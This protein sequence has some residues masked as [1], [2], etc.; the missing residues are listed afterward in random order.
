[1]AVGTV[2][3]TTTDI[4]SDSRGGYLGITKYSLAWIASAGGAVSGNPVTT[5]RGTLVAAKVVPGTGTPP[6]GGYGV[7]LVDTDGVD[8]LGG[9][10]AGQSATVGKYFP[11]L[12]PLIFDGSETLDLVISAAGNGGMG[13]VH[14]WVRG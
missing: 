6:T 3:V 11:F 13:T 14:L 10:G 4:G 9:L 8:V 12:P 1:M 7:T 5:V 2:A